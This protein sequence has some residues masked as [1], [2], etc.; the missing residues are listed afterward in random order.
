MLWQHAQELVHGVITKDCLLCHVE[1]PKGHVTK[2]S[3]QKNR[4]MRFCG[5]I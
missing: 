4:Q 2:K 5:Q 3:S 1:L